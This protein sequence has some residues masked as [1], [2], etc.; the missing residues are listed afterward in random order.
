MGIEAFLY[1][2]TITAD[3]LWDLAVNAQVNNVEHDGDDSALVGFLLR[4]WFVLVEDE[5]EEVD[6]GYESAERR[7]Q[8]FCRH[9]QAAYRTEEAPDV[10]EPDWPN[11][12]FIPKKFVRLIARIQGQKDKVAL[13]YMQELAR[14]H[15]G[16]NS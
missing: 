16:M 4:A 3:E 6:E 13:E 15:G 5:G 14:K 9:Y 7:Y 2:N 1:N 8:D 12:V 11:G 10:L